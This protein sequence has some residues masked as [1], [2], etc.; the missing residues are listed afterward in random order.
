MDIIDLLTKDHTEVN[1]LFGRFNQSS[2]SETQEELA[3]NIV[4]ELSVHAA[5]EEQFVYPLIRKN[6]DG[7]DEMVDHAIEEHQEVK[8][9]LADIEKLDAGNADFSSKME[10]VISSVREHVEEEEGDVL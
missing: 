1:E 8:Q 4:H 6:V 9:L 5:V 3:K 10:K 2:K 7:G